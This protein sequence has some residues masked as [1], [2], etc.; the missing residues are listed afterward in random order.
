METPQGTPRLVN[1]AA[2]PHIGRLLRLEKGRAARGCFSSN[3]RLATARSFPAT[4]TLRSRQ[5]RVESS[6]F[7]YQIGEGWR[8]RNTIT[9][10]FPWKAAPPS[11]R[12]ASRGQLHAIYRN[13]ERAGR[14]PHDATP[15]TPA[16]NRERRAWRDTEEYSP[17]GR[18]HSQLTTRFSNR[19]RTDPLRRA[20]YV[21]RTVRRELSPALETRPRHRSHNTSQVHCSKSEKLPATGAQTA[22][23]RRPQKPAVDG[24]EWGP[25]FNV[26]G[27]TPP[28]ETG[29]TRRVVPR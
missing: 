19:E 14:P 4:A 29:V 15:G 1:S 7:T 18:R 25:R 6:V 3:S 9:H 16:Q 26:R 11:R 10:A 20:R 27:D 13:R 28:V 17:R 8:G 23:P 22:N 2:P 24:G 5:P 12:Q 21:R